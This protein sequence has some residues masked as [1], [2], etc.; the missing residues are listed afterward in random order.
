MNNVNLDKY[1]EIVNKEKVQKGLDN[2]VPLYPMLR[3]D[4]E[5][6]YVTVPL[7][8]FMDNVWKREG[9][10]KPAYWILIDINTEKVI[11]FNKTEEK[12]FV[13]GDVIPKNIDG[14]QKELAKYTVEKTLQYKNYLLEDIKNGQLP[15]QKKLEAVLGDKIDVD[16]ETVDMGEYILANLEEE[17]KA[18]V[19]DLVALL[20][21]SKYGSITF[22][23][24]QLFN[25]ILKKYKETKTID[26]EKIKLCIEIMNNYYE[27]VHYIDNLF[28]L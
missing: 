19:D 1:L 14:T 22:Y 5:S 8:E 24:D 4:N 21:Q 7:T 25:L 13:I 28:N 18:K 2:Y 12:D 26:K 23:Y 9:K 6:L 10:V 16:G 17:I 11:E 3:V 20:V 27:G 15:I